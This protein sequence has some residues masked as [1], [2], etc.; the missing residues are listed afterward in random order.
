MHRPIALINMLAK[1]L[2]PCIAEDIMH[3]TEIHKTL[4]TT[5][6]AVGLGG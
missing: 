2:S 6:L 3:M 4:Q 1:V 5:I